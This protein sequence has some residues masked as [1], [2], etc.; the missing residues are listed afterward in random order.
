MELQGWENILYDKLNE[1]GGTIVAEMSAIIKSKGAVA[2]GNLINSLK[3]E[4]VFANGQFELAIEYADYGKFVNLGRNP[5]AKFPPMA[6]IKSWMSLKGIP[7]EALW[8]IMVK[9]KKGGFYSKKV[10][11][12]RGVD[13]GKAR[14]QTIYS[15]P[16]GINFTSPFETN[17]DLRKILTDFEGTVAATIQRELIDDFIKNKETR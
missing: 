12:I 9:I 8:P 2:S 6:S 1:L 13:A 11:M 4:V 17:L 16:V 5:S 7:Q 10:G 15:R 3:Y 14:Q